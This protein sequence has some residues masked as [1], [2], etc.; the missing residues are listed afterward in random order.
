MN[1]VGTGATHQADHPWTVHA[2]G[3]TGL[4]HRLHGEP[5]QDRLTW[6]TWKN[7][8]TGRALLV[9]LCSDGAGSARKSWAGAWMACRSIVMD[10]DRLTTRASIESS[11]YRP[12]FWNESRLIRL[13]R[14]ARSRTLRWSRLLNAQADDLAATLNMAIVGD[15]F[16]RFAQIGD[17]IM[18]FSFSD[19][20]GDWQLA[21][22]PQT[23]EFAGET[24]FL[25]SREWSENMRFRNL[26]IAPKRVVVSSDGL[27]P[28]LFDARSGTIHPKFVDPL[29]SALAGDV[30]PDSSK[31]DRLTRFLE[32]D[33]VANAC[34]DDLS[35]VLA[36]RSE[37]DAVDESVSAR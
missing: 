32:S 15:D 20:S 26:D 11:P 28:I 27:S 9:I 37:P 16:A 22:P 19:V 3:V 1:A 2:A 13:V 36:R 10:I 17:G 29:F 25:N 6:R 30:I 18:G 5:G 33:R 8:T 35:L 14:D 31:D 4:G 34:D 12:E 21:I 24:F 7:A 23:G